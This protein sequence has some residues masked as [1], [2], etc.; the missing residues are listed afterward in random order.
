MLSSGIFIYGSQI[1]LLLLLLMLLLR[2]LHLPSTPFFTS[3]NILL[4]STL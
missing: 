1:P 4:Y 3:F 2:L